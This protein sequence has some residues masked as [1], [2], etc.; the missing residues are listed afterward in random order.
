MAVFSTLFSVQML[1]LVQ[2]ETPSR[3]IEKV[4]ALIFTLHL[5]PALGKC[6]L[7]HPLRPFFRERIPSN[8][9]LGNYLPSDRIQ[10]TN[11]I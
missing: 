1:T 7:R 6:P 2:A 9:F 10:G 3:L 5:R 8:P 11:I 4:I